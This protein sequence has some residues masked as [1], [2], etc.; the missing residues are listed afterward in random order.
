M[1]TMKVNEI[2]N[3]QGGAFPWGDQEV[4]A[5]DSTTAR[6]LEDRFA[7]VVN[8]KDCGAVGDGVTD[9]T[10]AFQRAA[11]KIN[12][13]GGGVLVFPVTNGFYSITNSK[14]RSDDNSYYGNT[15]TFLFDNVDG[16]SIVG[17][18]ALIKVADGSKYGAFDRNTGAVKPYT[19]SPTDTDDTATPGTIFNF[20]SCKN[21]TV[22]DIHVN[23]NNENLVYGGDNQSDGLQLQNSCFRVVGDSSNIKFYN[24]SA[25]YMGLDGIAVKTTASEYT[26]GNGVSFTNVLSEYNGRQGASI[27]GGNGILLDS[28]QFR[29]TGK[30]GQSTAPGAG[31]DLEP[32]LGNAV[33]NLVVRNCEILNNTG[34]GL[35]FWDTGNYS[36]NVRIK[37]TS[38]WGNSNSALWLQ[39]GVSAY[40]DGCDIHGKIVKAENSSFTNCNIDTDVHPDYGIYVSGTYIAENQVNA[41]YKNCTFTP[42]LLRGPLYSVLIDCVVDCAWNSSL[43]PTGG[44]ATSLGAGSKRVELIDNLTGNF[45]D[46]NR[47][48]YS[49]GGG[50]VVD[51]IEIKGDG[52]GLRAYSRTGAYGLINTGKSSGQAYFRNESDT[53]GSAIL[54]GR[55]A[56][57]TS[58]DFIQG[59]IYL[60]YTPSPGGSIGW[61]CVAEGNPGTWKSFGVIAS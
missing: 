8:V 47:F 44:T 2:L 45:D 17:N 18:G 3:N 58:G 60:D 49:T 27:S 55:S 53:F 54:G 50:A 43:S 29:H 14:T 1:S 31:L 21:V 39:G 37:D 7:D 26:E 32:E 48:F 20:N 5:A 36:K 34:V 23:G 6:K 9:D 59:D 35:L 61:V 15:W 25:I 10:E 46:S 40:I 52:N 38:I 16:L 19:G 42:S 28:C 33:S 30:G 56:P 11:A 13:I 51:S 12:E 22:Y 4:T 57:P 41:T 24:C